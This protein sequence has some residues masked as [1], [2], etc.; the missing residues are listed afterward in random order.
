[1]GNGGREAHV[2]VALLVVHVDVGLLQHVE[3]F[4]RERVLGVVDGTNQVEHLRTET[5]LWWSTR[6][7][8]CGAN[9]ACINGVSDVLVEFGIIHNAAAERT[10]HRGGF[11][12]KGHT[13]MRLKKKL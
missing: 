6:T 4:K 7:G 9:L 8:R 2:D 5:T 1:M 11:V 3:L 10:E 13:K 12:F